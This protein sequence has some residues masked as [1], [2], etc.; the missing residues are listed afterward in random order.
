MGQG[1][2]PKLSAFT[3]FSSKHAYSKR[4]FLNHKLKKKMSQTNYFITMV[5]VAFITQYLRPDI[6]VTQEKLY[7]WNSNII[8]IFLVLCSVCVPK[9]C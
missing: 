2:A 4:F 9:E 1:A 5:S 8:Y 3:Q 7:F 6:L